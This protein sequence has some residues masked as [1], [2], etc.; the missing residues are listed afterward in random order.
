VIKVR[1]DDTRE[2]VIRAI[3]TYHLGAVPVVDQKDRLLGIVTSDDAL[4]ALEEEASEDVLTLAGAAGPLPTGHGVLRRVRARLPWLLVTLGGG[5][6]A[7]FLIQ[8][9]SRWLGREDAVG[10]LGRF[11]PIVA[12]MAGNVA[13]QSA[14]VM[15]RGFATGEI[16]ASRVKRVITDEILVAC[17]VGVLCGLIAGVIAVSTGVDARLAFSVGL[18]IALASAIAGVSGTVIPSICQRADIDPAIAAGPF[19]TTLNDLLGFLVYMVTAIA[20]LGVTGA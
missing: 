14:A 4:T 6:L 10:P 20:L 15:V 16:K 3:E 13:M 18:S 17:S 2:D 19:I 1:D 5:L 7:S 11:L 9:V 8:V 12:G